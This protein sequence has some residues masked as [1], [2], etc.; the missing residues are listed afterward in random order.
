MASGEEAVARYGTS[1][2]PIHLLLTDVIMPGMNGKVLAEQMKAKRPE[3]KVLFMSGYPH[4][5][6]SHQGLLGSGASLIHKPLGPAIL[7]AH[8]RRVLD[9]AA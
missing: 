4:D 5:A 6:L 8:V 3:I 1:P 7:A 9:S 2:E